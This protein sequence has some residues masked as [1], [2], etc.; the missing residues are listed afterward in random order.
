MKKIILFIAIGF[1]AFA[2]GQ[3]T[4]R[5][6]DVSNIDVEIKISRFDKDFWALKNSKNLGADLD[7]LVQK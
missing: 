7:K 2:C 4:S 3:K 6:A 5:K 1:L